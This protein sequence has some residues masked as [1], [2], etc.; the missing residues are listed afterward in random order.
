[1]VEDKILLSE[2]IPI[3]MK[4]YEL[5][6]DEEIKVVYDLLKDRY[7]ITIPYELKEENTTEIKS[8]LLRQLQMEKALQ[9]YEEE[10]NDE[11]PDENGWY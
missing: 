2:I 10:Y 3:L 4:R 11:I 8:D 9:D 7:V 1:M 5:R 6:G